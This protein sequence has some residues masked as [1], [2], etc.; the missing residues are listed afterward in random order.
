MFYPQTPQGG[1]F[2]ST[3]FFK[4]PLGDLGVDIKRSAFLTASSDKLFKLIVVIYLTIMD[5]KCFNCFQNTAN[6][7]RT[8]SKITE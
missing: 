3:H 4:S 6:E 5:F 8:T 2:N 7:E 1:L